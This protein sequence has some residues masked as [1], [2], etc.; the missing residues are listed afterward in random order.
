M[1]TLANKKIKPLVHFHKFN[2]V[3]TGQSLQSA[4]RPLSSHRTKKTQEVKIIEEQTKKKHL[5]KN[6][7]RLVLKRI[8]LHSHFEQDVS[9][10]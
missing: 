10:S 1:V 8:K 3:S 9:E 5:N 4:R 6:D 7:A 2:R